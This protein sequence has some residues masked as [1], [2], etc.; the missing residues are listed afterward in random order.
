MFAFFQVGKVSG[1]V[2]MTGEAVA[3]AT[4]FSE[5]VTAVEANL[6]VATVAVVTSEEVAEAVVTLAIVVV[7]NSA[8]ETANTTT[9]AVVETGNT[10]MIAAETENEVTVEREEVGIAE[11][12]EA[13]VNDASTTII[14]ATIS[15]VATTNGAP[16]RITKEDDGSGSSCTRRFSIRPTTFTFEYRSFDVFLSC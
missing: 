12:V 7:V 1:A 5:V 13:V 3:A 10:T 2:R 8:A 16:I 6:E 9:T 14:A 15:G 11:D 4:E